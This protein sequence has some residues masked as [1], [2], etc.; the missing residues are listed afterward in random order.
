MIAPTGNSGDRSCDRHAQHGRLRKFPAFYWP[1]QGS[2]EGVIQ[3]GDGGIRD[4]DTCTKYL[5][6]GKRR[7]GDDSG[8]G[9]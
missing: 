8:S 1:F 4:R 7:G 2:L 3:G 9:Y 6:M 5:E